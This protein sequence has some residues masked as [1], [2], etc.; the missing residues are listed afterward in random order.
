V[1]GV[2]DRVDLVPHFER[3]K[4]RLANGEPDRWIFCLAFLALQAANVSHGKTTNSRR[5]TE[6]GG[7]NNP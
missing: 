1:E 7:V 3:P 4:T 2:P 5:A 6:R